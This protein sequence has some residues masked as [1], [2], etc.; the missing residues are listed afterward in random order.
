MISRSKVVRRVYLPHRLKPPTDHT[1]ASTT[2]STPTKPEKREDVGGVVV[3]GYGDFRGGGVVVNLV[4]PKE[5]PVHPS[6]GYLTDWRPLLDVVPLWR[7]LQ[8]QHPRLKTLFL[9]ETGGGGDCLFH[10]LAAGFNH[11]YNALVYYMEQM[12]AVA[13]HQLSNLSPNEITEFIIDLEGQLQEPLKS[14]PHEQRIQALQKRIRAKGNAYW[15]ETGTL[16]QL[17]LKSPPFA[18]NKI[19]FAVVN[20]RNKPVDFRALTPEELSRFKQLYP[21]RHVP[22][23]IPVRWEPRVETTI[24][25]R[26]D[27]QYLMFMHCLENSHWVLLGYAP[28]ADQKHV[29]E[30]RIGSTFPI[31]HYPDPLLPFLQEQ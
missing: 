22:K 14:M 19:G 17:L 5:V 18:D 11:L 23:Q 24:L 30:T 6:G 9:L 2:V 25:R 16:R 10:V 21:H 15:G 13:A 3:G 20:I 31:N 27:T 4:L 7:K 26:P 28:H 8:D 1:P 29:A 12:R